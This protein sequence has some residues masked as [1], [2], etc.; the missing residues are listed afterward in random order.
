MTRLMRNSLAL[1]FFIFTIPFAG[2]INISGLVKD[3]ATGDP[4][5]EASVRLLAAKDSAFVKGVTT[6]L[7]GKFNIQGVKSDRK[8]VV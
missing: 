2:A 8:S 1:L 3:A 4:L 7:D 6:N 5:M